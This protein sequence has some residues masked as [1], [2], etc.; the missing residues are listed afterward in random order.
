MNIKLK[1]AL[2]YV[3]PKGKFN[4]IS[5][6]TIVSIVGIA[7][8]V[9]ALIIV[10]SIFNGFRITSKNAILD[11][12]PTIRII[13]NNSPFFMLDTSL[14]EKINNLMDVKKVVPVLQI[15]SVLVKNSNIDVVELISNSGDLLD[16]KLFVF[17]DGIISI[18]D[19]NKII[20]G[21]ALADRLK[22]TIF[23]TIQ[24]IGMNSLEK[25]FN[26]LRLPTGT[27]VIVG[28]MIITNIKD[29]DLTNCYTDYDIVSNIANVPVGTITQ[30]D[31]FSTESDIESVSKLCATIEK[32][33]PNDYKLQT[34]ID[35]NKDL[36]SIMQME[37]IAVF[38]VMSLILL[39]AIFNVFASLAMTVME[40]K[41]EI[42]LLK[43]LGT[44][45]RA[46]THI[47]IIEGV[48]IGGIGT[49]IGVVVG[50][51]FVLG[52]IN[53]SWFKLDGSSFIETSLPIALNH[54]EVILIC[55]L[56]LFLSIVAAYFPAKSATKKTNEI[57]LYNE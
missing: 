18:T 33:L 51:G 44:G 32:I 43:A 37:R 10:M 55:I 31:I 50:L 23:D 7:I 19:T 2:R 34:W 24:V 20:L 29:Y 3:F 30:I 12:D 1:I 15:K 22:V 49:I 38:C 47:Y 14:I 53:F 45:N 48:L 4:F 16:K 39:I 13:N 28:G 54:F 36:Y 52:Q 5:I 46:I 35:L 17:D 8:G 27:D 9:A 40:K 6:I 57:R 25:S 42:A 11:V 21:I 56:S 41:Q 26:S